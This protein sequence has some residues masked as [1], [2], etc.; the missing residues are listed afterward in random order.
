MLNQPFIK[1]ISHTIMYLFF[2]IMIIVSS[3]HL[4]SELRSSQKFSK[5][6]AENNLTSKYNSYIDLSNNLNYGNLVLIFLD[7]IFRYLAYK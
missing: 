2:I 4:A 5:Y 1:F 6:L 7:L 3:V